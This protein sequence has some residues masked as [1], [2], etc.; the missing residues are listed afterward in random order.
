M[1][2]MNARRSGISLIETVVALT[3]LAL[4]LIP[5][6]TTLMQSQVVTQIGRQELEVLNL[7]GSFLSQAQTM[8]AAGIPLVSDQAVPNGTS[9]ITLGAGQT[10]RLPAFSSSIQVKYS[11]QTFALATPPLGGTPRNAVVLTLTASWQ[12]ANGKNKSATFATLV[13]PT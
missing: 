1:I 8:Q 3:V 11:A 12:D 5:L 6:W 10:I 2:C 13:K 4:I 7:G 9:Q